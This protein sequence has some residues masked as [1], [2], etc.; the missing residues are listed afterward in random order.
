[1]VTFTGAPQGAPYQSTFLV[2]TTTNASAAAVITATGACSIAAN[3]VTM[4]SGTGTCSLTANWAADSNYSAATAALTTTATTIAPTV[5]FTG[6]PPSTGYQSKFTVSA[7]TNASIIATITA[8]GA[9][10]ITGNNVTM[11]SGTGMC[12]LTAN[13]AA[14][15]NYSAATATQTTAAAKI[16]PTVTFTGA[17][18]TA[19][20]Q[21][22]FIVSATTNAST[23]AAITAT[24]ACSIMGNTVTMASGTDNGGHNQSG[25]QLSH[26]L[27]RVVISQLFI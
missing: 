18:T 2:A 19:P 10:S 17:P 26:Y 24:G 14:D 9:C 11:T 25:R 23:T 3:T 16:A 21:S 8:T 5:T 1:M 27:R 20:Y 12:N 15:S 6:A 22:T 4:T 13:W 7:T